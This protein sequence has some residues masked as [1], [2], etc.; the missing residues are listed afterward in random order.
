MHDVVTKSRYVLYTQVNSGMALGTGPHPFRH[1]AQH[2][3]DQTL[4]PHRNLTMRRG[5][6][7]N[8]LGHVGVLLLQNRRAALAWTSHY[9]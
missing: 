7:R 6:P 5:L 4:W 9:V 8:Q 1:Q 3:Y 2:R